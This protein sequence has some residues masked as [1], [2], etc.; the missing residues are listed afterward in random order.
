[1]AWSKVGSKGLENIISTSSISQQEAPT[2]KYIPSSS[3]KRKRQRMPSGSELEEE[4]EDFQ[5]SIPHPSPLSSIS[6][7]VLFT[8][9]HFKESFEASFFD[10]L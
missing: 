10:S 9:K 7:S 3:G 6:N 1:M 8:G 5:S 4:E 2:T